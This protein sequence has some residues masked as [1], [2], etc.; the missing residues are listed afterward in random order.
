VP[1][2]TGKAS[3]PREIDARLVLK[4]HDQDAVQLDLVPDLNVSVGAHER[5]HVGS[6]KLQPHY[7]LF[8]AR[9]E[10][11]LGAPWPFEVS[12]SGVARRIQKLA[13]R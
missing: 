13:S 6:R 5:H 11:Y 9:V 12:F 3:Q 2:A 4:S 10:S 1:A 8:G 7:Q